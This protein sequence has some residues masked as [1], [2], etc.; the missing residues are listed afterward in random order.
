MS[1]FPS[2]VVC[3]MYERCSCFD[4]YPSTSCSCFLVSQTSL[5]SASFFSQ[6]FSCLSCCCGNLRPSLPSSSCVLPYFPVCLAV[7]LFRPETR[8]KEKECKDGRGGHDLRVD[9]AL[10]L[11]A[12]QEIFDPLWSF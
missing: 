12:M 6:L 9:V 3:K 5:L 2:R 1:S 8:E 7:E 10:S 11:Q 4:S